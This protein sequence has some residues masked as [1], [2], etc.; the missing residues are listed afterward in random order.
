MPLYRSKAVSLMTSVAILSIGHTASAQN[1]TLQQC[2]AAEAKKS[3]FSGVISIM[4][5]GAMVT[6]ANGLMAGKGSAKMTA[7]AQFNIGSA[8]K[9][10]TAVAIAQLVD[11]KKITLDDPIGR[12]VSGLT[13]GASAVTIRQLLT[14]S[15][16]LGNFFVPENLPLL[17]RARSLAELKPL[18]TSDRPAF[19]PGSKS[20]Y[21]NSGFLLL[22]LII[23]Q[24]S[25][26]SYGEYL[27]KNVF[28]PAGMTHSGTMPA[29]ANIR[30]VGMTNMPEDGGA[31]SGPPPGPPPG[32]GTP[33]PGA[34][35][36]PPPPG[37]QP[38]PPPGPMMM[39]PPPG[40]LRASQEASMMGTSAGGSFSTP[41]DMQ[42]F[43][44][45]LLAG[46]LTSTAMRDALTSPQIELLPEKG[47]L[48]AINYG[49]GF[50]VADHKGH[51]WFGHNGGLPGGNVA[52]AAFAKDQVTAVIMANRD[53]P[54][55]DMML[56]RVQAMLFDGGTCA[57]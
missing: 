36:G 7:D 9:M 20:Q 14:H 17:A 16:G 24:V 41:S 42:R 49:F 56:R 28:T 52:T 1:M 30:A 12:H 46:K 51:G 6:Y 4:R 22:G 31:E 27:Q 2:V 47:P 53:P 38:G 26:Q 8:G 37:A 35:L 39:M 19:T 21:S 50:T 45:A 48:P 33:P 5:P 57:G 3:N 13:P 44:A 54:A 10:W 29:T 55:A 18:V 15:G 40:P 32:R 34:R 25:G 11:A 43:F 23:E